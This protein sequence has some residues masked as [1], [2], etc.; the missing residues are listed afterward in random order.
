M[1]KHE[2]SWQDRGKLWFRMGIRLILTLVVL[3]F[4]VV[5]GKPLISL[6]FP[7]VLAMMMAWLLN[8]AVHFLQKKLGG[9]RSLL[10]M[11]ILFLLFALAGAALFMVN[12][13]IF[14][15]IR[16]LVN[17]WQSIWSSFLLAL[18]RIGTLGQSWFSYLPQE[19]GTLAD[20]LITSLITWAQDVIPALVSAT[21]SWAGTA[22]IKLPSFGVATVVFIMGSYFIM[23]DYPHLRYLVIERMS[24]DTLGLL[25]FIKHTAATAL[26]GYVKAELILSVGVFFILLVGFFLIG[27]SYALLLA[28]LLAV[29]DFIPIIGAGTVMVPWAVVSFFTQ[30]LRTAVELMAIWGVILLFR[31]VAEPKVVGNQTGLS[32]ILS[33]VSIYVGMKVAGVW[34]MIFGPVVVL[35]IIN[36]CRAGV[37]DGPVADVRMAV[38]DLRAVLRNR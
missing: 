20:R 16:N 1:D 6:F 8:P 3:V 38:A 17:D 12:Y 25:R 34:G 18:E 2:L 9:S 11:L 21:A 13:Q 31:R 28:L 7:F 30:D 29:M 24:A 19:V 10:S 5:L 26:G 27:Q 14:V 4:L 15:E 22:A 32:P 23:A 37:F 36:V 35:V 33:L